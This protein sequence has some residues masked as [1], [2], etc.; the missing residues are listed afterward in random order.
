MTKGENKFTGGKE[1]GRNHVKGRFL[2]YKKGGRIEGKREGSQG[3][4]KKE[5][6]SY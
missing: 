5:F 1:R 4:N 3:N 6:L 2:K